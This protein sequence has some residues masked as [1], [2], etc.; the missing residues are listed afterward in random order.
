MA[1]KRTA[2]KFEF[3]QPKSKFQKLDITKSNSQIPNPITIINVANDSVKSINND[4]TCIWEDDD[5]ELFLL[6]SQKAE[7]VNAMKEGIGTIDTFT[8]F[9]R[10]AN[11][12]SSLSSTQ[13][14]SDSAITNFL[15]DNDDD[16]VLSQIPTFETNLPNAANVIGF[17]IQDKFPAKS[18]TKVLTSTQIPSTSKNSK[19]QHFSNVQNNVEND[20]N[21]KAC[22]NFME[23]DLEKQKT[24]IESLQE[25]IKIAHEIIQTKDGETKMLRYDLQL[26]KKRN[27]DLRRE[28]LEE[29]ERIKC[30]NMTKMTKLEYELN[31]Q[32]TELE[33][34]VSTYVYK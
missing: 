5:D 33:F 25:K 18:I 29:T 13:Q 28:K 27:D 1:S 8:Q 16:L 26:I 15:D 3:K 24:F 14:K 2:N 9:T 7:K 19:I 6:A 12:A 20:N 22:I 32:K 30:E 21:K 31:A 10:D 23:E 17:S 11:P 4:D 34:K